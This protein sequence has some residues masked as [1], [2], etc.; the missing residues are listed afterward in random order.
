[1]GAGAAADAT[2]GSWWPTRAPPCEVLPA[3]HGVTAR[4]SAR[5]RGAGTSAGKGKGRARAGRAGF[6]QRARTEAA[7]C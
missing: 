2:G 4:P 7:A 1:M 3:R 5:G 6:G